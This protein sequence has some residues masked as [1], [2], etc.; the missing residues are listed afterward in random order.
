MSRNLEPAARKIKLDILCTKFYSQIKIRDKFEFN[1]SEKN[2]DEIQE[3][4]KQTSKEL[5]SLM[6]IK[7]R[8]GDK[9]SREGK[10]LYSGDS[11]CKNEERG[12]RGVRR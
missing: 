5:E 1:L 6:N 7:K 3:N 9:G 11:I 4:I 12:Y 8:I 2:Y 10:Y